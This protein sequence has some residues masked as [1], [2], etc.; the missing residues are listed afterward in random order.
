MPGFLL[1]SCEVGGGSTFQ[2]TTP[3][4]NYAWSQLS[5]RPGDPAI[6]VE[7]IAVPGSEW[8]HIY[9]GCVLFANFHCYVSQNN[10]FFLWGE[11]L[12][13]KPKIFWEQNTE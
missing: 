13:Q 7:V 12:K 8:I 9:V 1:V 3:T 4:S 5:G 2:L 10:T 6:H 11:S